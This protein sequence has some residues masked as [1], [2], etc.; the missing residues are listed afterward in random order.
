MRTR[1]GAALAAVLLA[2]CASGRPSLSRPARS[3][4][5]ANSDASAQPQLPA[6]LRQQP[7][8]ATAQSLLAARGPLAAAARLRGGNALEAVQQAYLNLPLGTRCWSSLIGTLAVLSQIGLLQ[9]EQV[10]VDAHAIVKQLQIW[11]PVT[12]ASFLGGLGPQLIQKLYYLISYGRQL[13]ATLGLGEYL[14]VLAS[15]AAALTFLFHVLGWQFTADGMI[16]GIT[17]LCAQQMPDAQISLYGLNIPYAAA[18]F[19]A[20]FCAQCSSARTTLY[21]YAYLPFAQLVMS[22]VFQQQVPF[23]DIA[24]LLVGYAHYHFNDNLKPDSA[25]PAPP[26]KKGARAGGAAGGATK[27]KRRSKARMATIADLSDG[28]AQ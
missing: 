14:R 16:M 27:K 8:A 25:M 20:Q 9:P 2:A 12:A 5:S 19:S 1:I 7:R 26:A 28:N 23:T 17:V 13:E 11:R 6:A 24:G 3:D 21:R 10:A 18:H 4:R 15:L 22:Y